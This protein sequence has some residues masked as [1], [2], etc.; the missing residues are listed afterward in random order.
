MLSWVQD[1]IQKL[2]RRLRAAL[3][4]RGGP[5]NGP[6]SA[7][8]GRILSK[9]LPERGI[10]IKAIY[11]NSGSVPTAVLGCTGDW[12]KLCDIWDNLRPEDIVGEVSKFK[13]AVKMAKSDL[14]YTLRKEPLQESFF[15]NS[16]LRKLLRE[17]FDPNRISCPPALLA[18]FPAVDLLTNEYII[19]SN[20]IPG[21]IEWFLEGILGSMGLVPFLP[22]QRVYNPEKAGL[23]EKGKAKNNSLLLIDG[24]FMGNMLLEEATRDGYDIIFLIDIHGLQLA[25]TEF[26]IGKKQHWG[27]LLRSGFHILSSTNDRRQFQMDERIDEEIR[28]KKLLLQLRSRL[29]AEY[30]E[31]LQTIIQRM[32][33]GRLRLGD[34][35]ETQRI[36][37]SNPEYSSLFNFTNFT[38]HKETL[39]FMNAAHEAVR[40]AL[41]E[42]DL[43]PD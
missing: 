30:A 6:F 14:S 37:V 1:K 29:P 3:V 4:C 35:E 32:N 43:P 17:N 42:L 16:A 15:D 2:G 28:I 39:E 33:Q 36:L 13:I 11:A 34:K 7:E 5:E 41:Q 31:E 8:A 12:E 19:F 25:E 20:N 26:D 18:R 9:E 22:P 10:D 24:G 27:K 40:R 23:I 38:R 21:H